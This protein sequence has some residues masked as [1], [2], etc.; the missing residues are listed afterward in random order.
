MV[1]Q[2]TQPSEMKAP[3]ITP[4]PTPMAMCPMATMCKGMME[5]PPSGFFVML[6]GAVLI[7]LGMLIFF[8]P[9][10]IIWLI[11]GAFICLASRCS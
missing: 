8:E 10:I 5:K 9:R 6:A 2:T 3:R 11:G 1:E 4:R 7:A